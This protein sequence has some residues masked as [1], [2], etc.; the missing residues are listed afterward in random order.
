MRN[1][2]LDIPKRVQQDLEIIRLA[3]NWREL[4]S[5]KLNR[6][7]FS[8][9]KLRNGVVLNAPPEV[10]LN[11]LFHEIWLD[12]IYSPANYEIKPNDIVLDIGG[13]IGVFALYAATR[14]KNVEVYSY[15][16]FPEN[17][18]Y[19]ENNL[20]D[21]K[22]TNIH[23]FNAAVSDETGVRVLR[24]DDSWIKHSLNEKSSGEES[25]ANKGV[26]VKSF[27]LDDVLRQVEKCD[28]LKLDCEGS[29]YEILYA[30]SPENLKKVK[31][32]VGEYHNL[33]DEKRNGESL[34]KFLEENNY[35]IDI[36]E[37]LDD[38]SGIVCAKLG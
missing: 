11:F 29:E 8:A 13:N 35:K 18:R 24:V 6:K 17:A 28:F 33:D 20:R 26:S 2:I 3:K 1:K 7:G 22:L 32:I 23:F 19:F 15:E 30:C 34:K 9:V 27:S 10:D 14:Y 37:K 16:P 5:A 25:S 36:F 31:K 4:L 21:S 38:K 12:K